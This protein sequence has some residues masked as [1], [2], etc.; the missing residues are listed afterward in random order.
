M[1]AES[2]DFNVTESISLMGV[3]ICWGCHNIISQTGWLKPQEFVFSKFWPLFIQPRSRCQQIWFLLSLLSLTGRWPS[4]CYILTGTFSS[5]LSLSFLQGY[6][7]LYS[8]ASHLKPH[9]ILVASL[10][11]LCP[12]TVTMGLVL[13]T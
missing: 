11:G 7:S 2:M 8:R 13:Q 5:L 3:F 12:K 10:K 6:H 9:L 4:F 1:K